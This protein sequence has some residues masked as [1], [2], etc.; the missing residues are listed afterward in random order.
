MR[1]VTGRFTGGE[2]LSDVYG[3]FGIRVQRFVP[4]VRRAGAT[5]RW[6]MD[7]P[8]AVEGWHAGLRCVGRFPMWAVAGGRGRGPGAAVPVLRLL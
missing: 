1:R 7:D 3:S 2:L 6:G 8:T 5:P 4:A